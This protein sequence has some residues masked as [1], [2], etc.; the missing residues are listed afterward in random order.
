MINVLISSLQVGEVIMA[1]YAIY[2]L[3]RAGIYHELK[4][5]VKKYLKENKHPVK[6]YISFDPRRLETLEADNTSRFFKFTNSI[7]VN[8]GPI[9]STFYP[10]SFS[11]SGT[12]ISGHS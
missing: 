2:A 3:E 11:L 10:P 6:E 5:E 1:I 7:Q 12:S 8:S 9:S 4:H